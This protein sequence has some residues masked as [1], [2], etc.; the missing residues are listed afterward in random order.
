M[1]KPRR[2]KY[3]IQVIRIEA[4]VSEKDASKTFSAKNP[5]VD[6]KPWSH[7]INDFSDGIEELLKNPEA[8]IIEFPI[9]YAAI[10]KTAIEDQTE[11]ISA[12]QTFEGITDTNGVLQVVYDDETAK[13]GR[14]AEVTLQEVENDQA[15]CDLWF[16]EKTLFGMQKYQLK[17]ATETQNAVIA[18]L[19]I[20][21][22]NEMKTEVTLH[23]GSWIGMGGLI[24]EKIESFDSGEEKIIRT[25][26]FS[27]VRILPPKGAP[28]KS[29]QP[30]KIPNN[31]CP[32]LR[33]HEIIL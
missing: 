17:R 25:K 31:L 26:K 22:N 8:V 11:T 27:F 4:P 1:P 5:A 15:T 9:V 21:K 19:P 7:K 13:I 30:K 18:S 33:T 16:Y 24:S 32:G 29:T 2:G 12:P 6:T 14:Y 23:L 3:A 20:F 28:F 10:G